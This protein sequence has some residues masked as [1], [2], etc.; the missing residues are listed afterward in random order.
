MAV[1]DSIEK[2]DSRPILPTSNITI[3]MDLNVQRVVRR[4]KILGDTEIKTV[5]RGSVDQCSEC[6]KMPMYIGGHKA[7][8]F[9]YVKKYLCEEC[10]RF[11]N[12]YKELQF[13]D[14]IKSTS[15]YYEPEQ[16]RVIKTVSKSRGAGFMVE[17][18]DFRDW[19]GIK[20]L[21]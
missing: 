9:T 14:R 19:I 1:S 3:N 2:L 7:D 11:A 13:W 20:I 4:R 6:G 15:H 21:S 5:Y 16:S 8:P 18:K 10:L 12:R 17:V